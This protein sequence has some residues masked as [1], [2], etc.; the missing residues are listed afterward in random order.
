LLFD[1]K[2]VGAIGGSILEIQRID[3]RPK[4]RGHGTN[5]IK[6]M[7]RVARERRKFVYN[8]N[9]KWIRV[10]GVADDTPEDKEALEHILR[11]MFGFEHEGEGT[12]R[13]LL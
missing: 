1:G 9:Q 3:V 2:Q 8:V 6:L 4:R 10:Q 12:S 11:D 13:L 7:I 5:F